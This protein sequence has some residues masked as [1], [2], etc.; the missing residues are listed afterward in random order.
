MDDPAYGV[1]LVDKVLVLCRE[2]DD[3]LA[4]LVPPAGQNGRLLL[5]QIENLN[6]RRWVVH[7]SK[8]KRE[9]EH[10]Q[11][12]VLTYPHQ[13]SLKESYIRKRVYFKWGEAVHS[14]L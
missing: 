12:S 7:Y 4:L 3:G 13:S 6:G 10:I 5:Q 14:S 11:M 1:A 2:G 9:K 8:R